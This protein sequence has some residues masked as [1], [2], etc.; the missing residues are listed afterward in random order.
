MGNHLYIKLEE[1]FA[2]YLLAAELARWKYATKSE[3]PD[4]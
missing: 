3:P 4:C 1:T 2:A